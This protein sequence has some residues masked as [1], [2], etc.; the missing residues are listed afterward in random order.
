MTPLA[1]KFKEKTLAR[2]EEEKEESFG[3]KR[4]QRCQTVPWYTKG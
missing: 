3:K 1:P 4:C 2:G